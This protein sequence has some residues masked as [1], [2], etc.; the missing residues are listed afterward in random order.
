LAS[1]AFFRFFFFSRPS[2]FAFGA[3]TVRMAGTSVG[4]TNA[5]VNISNNCSRV[6]ADSCCAAVS[7][8]S[9]IKRML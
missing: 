6:G 1:R 8:A 3:L 7:H 9:T 5:V 4:P 2:R